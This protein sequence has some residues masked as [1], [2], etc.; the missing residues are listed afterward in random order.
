MTATYERNDLLQLSVAELVVL[1]K[2]GDSEAMDALFTRYQRSVQAIA[3]RRLGN[4]DEALELSQD[5]FIQAY[6]RLDQLQVPAAF[7]GWIRMITQRLAVNR[8]T[9]PT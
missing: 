8:F 4:W 7:G 5:V 9:R 2:D 1:A 6:R 3:Y